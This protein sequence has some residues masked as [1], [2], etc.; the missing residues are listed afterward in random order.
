MPWLSQ[1][2]GPALL[3]MSTRP[4]HDSPSKPQPLPRC[5]AVPCQDAT[6]PAAPSKGAPFDR[7]TGRDRHAR[8]QSHG[9]AARLPRCSAG[10]DMHQCHGEGCDGRQLSHFPALQ[11]GAVPAPR[12]F[13][14]VCAQASTAI[15]RDSFKAVSG[16]G[17]GSKGSIDTALSQLPPI[18]HSPASSGHGKKGVGQ[19]WQVQDSNS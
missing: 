11:A 12:A 10:L 18:A 3:L 19:T 2:R 14:S 7:Q 8:R 6:L 13:V 17:L 9:E 5:R 16:G 15:A 4:L 1:L